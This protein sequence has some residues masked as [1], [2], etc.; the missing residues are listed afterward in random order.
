LAHKDDEGHPGTDDYHYPV[1]TR[2]DGK[3]DPMPKGGKNDLLCVSV[4]EEA[5]AS[6]FLALGWLIERIIIVSSLKAKATT[7]YVLL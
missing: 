2:E 1:T 4:G 6:V 3:V 5:Q 7:K